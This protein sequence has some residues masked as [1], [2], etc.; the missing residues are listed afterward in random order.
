MDGAFCCGPAATEA[1]YDA[2]AAV[3]AAVAAGAAVMAATPVIQL[4]P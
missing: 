1:M 3:V 2:V 4:C